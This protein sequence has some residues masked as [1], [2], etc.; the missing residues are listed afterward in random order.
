VKRLGTLAL[1]GLAT[2]TL[3]ADRAAAAP[4]SSS[5]NAASLFALKID[6]ADLSSLFNAVG[7]TAT[8]YSVSSGSLTFEAK[9]KVEPTKQVQIP[10]LGGTHTLGLLL[11]PSSEIVGIKIDPIRPAGPPSSSPI[12]EART[13]LLYALGSLAIGW[14]VV[15]TRR[16]PLGTA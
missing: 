3:L 14:A 11:G 12:P 8:G 2:A 15:R 6:E 5:S 4:S 9:G 1:I 13:I 10:V 16:S 7:L